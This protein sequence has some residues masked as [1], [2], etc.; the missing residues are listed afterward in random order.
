MVVDPEQ[1]RLERLKPYIELMKALARKDIGLE[2]FE[3]SYFDL[4][5]NDPTMW[6]DAE[7][8]VLNALFLDLDEYCADPSLRKPGDVDENEMVNRVVGALERL[9]A[10]SEQ[11][12]VNSRC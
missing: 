6:G 8:R 3:R 11:M 10:I 2:Q 1:L 7:F 12:D 9:V 5:K 4:F